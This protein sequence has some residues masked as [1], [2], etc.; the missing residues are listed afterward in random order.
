MNFTGGQFFFSWRDPKMVY[1]SD[2]D[3]GKVQ[4]SYSSFDLISFLLNYSF[5]MAIKA[6]PPISN[7]HQSLRIIFNLKVWFKLCVQRSNTA[8]QVD[9]V[10][11]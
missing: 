4:V 7:T 6:T 1:H 8:C 11:N 3:Y 5:D 10:L 2:H 9:Y